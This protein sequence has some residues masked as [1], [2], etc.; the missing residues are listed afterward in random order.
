MLGRVRRKNEISG[1]QLHASVL[2]LQ[3]CCAGNGKAPQ[4]AWVQRNVRRSVR[5][6]G[7]TDN[8]TVWT[9]CFVVC[10]RVYYKWGMTD[11]NDFPGVSGCKASEHCQLFLLGLGLHADEPWEGV[12]WC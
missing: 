6:P 11:R 4:C 2:H 5:S 10:G 12:K 8:L 9:M 1:F 3:F 7:N